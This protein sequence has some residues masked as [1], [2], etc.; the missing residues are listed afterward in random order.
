MASDPRYAA[1]PLYVQEVEGLGTVRVD[2]VDPDADAPLIHSW[3]SAERARFWGMRGASPDEVREVY[4]H[5]DSLDTHH[6]FLA[7]LDG[8]PAALFQTYE[9]EADRVSEC[10]DPLPGDLGVH[11]MVGPAATPRPGYSGALLG[12]LFAFALRDRTRL[13]AEPDAANAKAIARLVRC[14]F[15][16]GPLVVL[17]EVDLPEVHIPAKRARLTFLTREPAGP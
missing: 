17:P 9:P 8:E 3:V 6:G 2:P 14:G 12:A 13:V 7:R 1:G 10:Y 4:A 15:T 5:L 11:L 16:L